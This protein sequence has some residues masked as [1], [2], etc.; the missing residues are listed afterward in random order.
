MNRHREPDD[1]ERWRASL[2]VLLV[3]MVATYGLALA[4]WAHLG[5]PGHIAG[6]AVG[7][8]L[9]LLALVDR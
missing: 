6:S 9:T 7:Y 2:F 8:V 3:G 1:L 4:G 5:W